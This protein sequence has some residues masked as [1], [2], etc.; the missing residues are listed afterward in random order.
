[1]DAS[2]VRVVLNQSEVVPADGEATD[3]PQ[4]LPLALRHL[5]FR[6]GPRAETVS[7]GHVLEDSCFFQPFCLSGP[8]SSATLTFVS[9]RCVSVLHLTQDSAILQP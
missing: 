5:I 2:S 9:L 3:S 7:V 1:M 6:I 8:F 4:W